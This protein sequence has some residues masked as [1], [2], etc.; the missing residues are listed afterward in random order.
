MMLKRKNIIL[1]LVILVL[2]SFNICASE[3]PFIGKTVYLAISETQTQTGEIF[4]LVK[5]VEEETG[6]KIEFNIM[7]TSKDGEIDK[8]LIGLMAGDEIDIIYKTDS[9]LKTYYNAGLLTPLKKLA[10]QN[11][12]NMQKIYGYNLPKFDNKIYGL[13]VFNDIWLTFYNKKIFDQAGLE[14]PKADNWTWEKYI[15]TAKKLTNTEKDIYGSYMLAYNNYNYMWAVQHGIAHYNKAG[16]TNYDKEIFAES[17]KFYYGLGNNLKIQPDSISYASGEY[18]WNSFLAS[19]NLAMFVC[20]GWLASLLP[21]FENYPRDWEVGILP[22]PYPEGE[23]PSTLAVTGNYAIPTTSKNKE[24]AFAAISFMAENQY[25][26]GYGRIPAR[27]DL[28]DKEINNYI[29]NQL[30]PKFATDNISTAD[31][32]KAW[33]DPKRKIYSEK[34]IGVADTTINQIWDEEGKLYGQG[35]KSLES[36]IKAIK[37][38][39]DQAIKDEKNE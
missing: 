13:P 5:K 23:T 2:F 3:K 38:R 20:G 10:K 24:A 27:V 30:T 33:F 25:K 6:I 34:L 11:N 35:Q 26:L 36:A 39:A 22:M 17:L 15:E 9:K 8:T 7:P 19:D 32:K 16:L 31:F 4:E 14:Y 12:Y 29:E 21:D 28:S 1:V 37:S 18:A